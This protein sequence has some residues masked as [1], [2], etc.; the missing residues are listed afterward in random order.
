MRSLLLDTRLQK[1]KVIPRSSLED[2]CSYIGCDFVGFYYRN[3]GGRTFAIVC[4]D[5]ED[6]DQNEEDRAPTAFDTKNNP[7]FFGNL[8]ICKNDKE[9]E[10]IP[11][12]DADIRHICKH[13]ILTGNGAEQWPALINVDKPIRTE[14]LPDA[15]EI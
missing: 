5:T 11:L 6:E 15:D 12:T 13:T 9:G 4:A 2:C 8:V 7:V 1:L 3:I 14:E 10:D